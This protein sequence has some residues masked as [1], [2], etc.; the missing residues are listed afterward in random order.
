MRF[1]KVKEQFYAMLD[2]YV[3]HGEGVARVSRDKSRSLIIRF[4]AGIYGMILFLV[5]L[6]LYFGGFVA[7]IMLGIS[8]VFIFY[9]W[10]E[11]GWFIALILANVGFIIFLFWRGLRR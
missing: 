9:I 4:V 2:A 3:A 8:V 5:G 7:Y 6:V 1:N 10:F 11:K